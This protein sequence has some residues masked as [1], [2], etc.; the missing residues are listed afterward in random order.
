[1]NVIPPYIV[2]NKKVG[3]TPLSCLEAWRK[4]HPNLS[5]TPLAY[6]GRLDPMASGKLLIL[7]GETCKNQT[8]YHQLDKSYEFSVLFGVSS[9]SGD[10]LGL[11]TEGGPRLVQISAV[12]AVLKNLVGKISLPYPVFSA[13]TVAGKPLHTWAVEGKINEIKLPNK[14]SEIYSL[15]LQTETKLTRLQIYEAAR[16]KIELIP[17]V[18]DI[19]KALGN[20]F[21]RPDIRIAWQ[22]F[23]EN[24]NP[25]DVFSIMNFGCDASS[26]TYMR[27]LAEV[28]ARQLGTTGLA[29][30]IHRQKIGNFNPQTKT[31]LREF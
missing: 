8:A 18:T 25:A 21:R 22:K 11:A 26:G 4:N 15:I 24:G 13:R 31:W 14:E 23:L 19:R 9:D 1:M 7:I 2:L 3:E 16:H 20:D 6:A 27:T 30:S 5:D 28:I 29:W 10:V 12:E 17:P